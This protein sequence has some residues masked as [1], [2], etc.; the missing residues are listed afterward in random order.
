MTAS[1]A[2]ELGSL[3]H[4]LEEIER[5]IVAMTAH[6][7]GGRRDDVLAALFTAERAL[8]AAVRDVEAARRLLR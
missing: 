7:G 3:V 1:D 4:A 2:A 8:R 5:R 6:Y